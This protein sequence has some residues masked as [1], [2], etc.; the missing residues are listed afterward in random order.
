MVA[1][2]VITGIFAVLALSITFA[3]VMYL[4]GRAEG[5]RHRK[6]LGS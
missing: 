6:R 5:K 1:G 4:D 3:V 2:F